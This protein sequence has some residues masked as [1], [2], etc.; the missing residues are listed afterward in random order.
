[1]RNLNPTS[2]T[3]DF[4]FDLYSLSHQK[5]LIYKELKILEGKEGYPDATKVNGQ[6]KFYEPWTMYLVLFMIS[7]RKALSSVFILDF[8]NSDTAFD[9][10]VFDIA[11]AIFDKYREAGLLDGSI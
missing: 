4:D 10:G 5:R 9:N 7:T 6:Y 11:R 2:S 3:S 8:K 1:M